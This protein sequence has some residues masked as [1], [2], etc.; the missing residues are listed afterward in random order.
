MVDFLFVM[1]Y[2]CELA[3]KLCGTGITGFAKSRWNIFEAVLVT[4]STLTLFPA[5]ESFRLQAGRPFRFLRIFRIV[6]YVDSLK[7]I[8]NRIAVTLPSLIQIITLQ[9]IFIIIYAGV[10]TQVFADVKYGLHMNRKVNF[11]TFT[12]SF[13]ILFHSMTGEGWRMVMNDLKLST[14][15]CTADYNGKTDC[16]SPFGSTAFFVTYIIL[17]TYILTNLFVATILDYVSFGI[18]K[19]NTLLSDEHLEKYQKL[20]MQYDRKGEGYLK[21]HRVGEFMDRLGTPI[22]AKNMHRK[23]KWR[24]WWQLLSIHE[25]CVRCAR[26]T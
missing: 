21:L 1:I 6:R 19:S 11:E 26:A 3:I 16:G 23:R 20:W 4:L 24:L 9:M 2:L 7:K 10:A 22:I 14:P 8:L 25:E 18:L 17:C 13:L 15:S 5:K 12:N